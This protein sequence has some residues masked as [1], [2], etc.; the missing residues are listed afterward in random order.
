MN[1]VFRSYQNETDQ[2]TFLNTF[3]LAVRLFYLQFRLIFAQATFFS[4][5]SAFDDKNSG[6]SAIYNRDK[7]RS[8]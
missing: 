5:E 3:T 4:A 6:S 2:N 1:Q 8:L 7:Q